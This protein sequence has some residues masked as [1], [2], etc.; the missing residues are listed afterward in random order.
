MT[1]RGCGVVGALLIVAQLGGGTT[2]LQRSLEG[3]GRSSTRP[4]PQ[5]PA[6]PPSRPSD[7]W[8]PDRLVSDPATGQQIPVPGHWE[9][10]LPSG[11][12]YGPPMV[13]CGSSGNCAAIPAGPRPL[14]EGRQNP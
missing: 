7:V 12:L 14:P 9:R 6:L 11:E 10:R 8:V 3:I 2:P 5:A 4:V 13:I 1:L